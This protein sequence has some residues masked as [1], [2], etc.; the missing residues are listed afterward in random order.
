MDCSFNDFWCLTASQIYEI[1]ANK[2]INMSKLRQI[3]KLYCQRQGTRTISNITGVSRNTVKKY[4]SQFR[5]LKVP[6][7][8]VFLL[9]DPDLDTLFHVH[10]ITEGSE[11]LKELYAFFPYAENK[12]KRPGMTLLLLW[13]EY[14]EQQPGRYENTAFYSH[15]KKWKGQSHPSMHMV[16]KAGDKMFV[17]YAGKKLPLTDPSTGEIKQMEVFVAILGASQ[18]TYVEA[19][20]SQD[21]EDFINAC[22][23]ALHYFGGAPAAIVPDNLKA[24]VIKS[25]RYEPRL[26]NN[27]EAFADHYGMVVLPARTYKPKD[28]ALVEGAVKITYNRI[29]TKLQE[30]TF[31]LLKEMNEAIFDCLTN[32]N[33]SDFQGRDYSRIEQ[34]D[35]MEKA[36]LQALPAM[37]FAMRDVALVKVMKHGHI[38]LHCDKHYYSVPYKYIGENVKILYSKAKV[39]IYLK[40]ELIATHDRIK[41]PH[42]YTTEPLHMA[43]YHQYLTDWNPERFLSEAYLIH[44]DVGMFI[45]QV[46]K[47]KAHPEQAYKSCQGILSFAK[48][49]G[50]ERLIK[51][52]RRAHSYEQFHYKGIENI[53]QRNLDQYEIEEEP[54]SMPSHD[55][56]RGENNYK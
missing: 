45:E 20:G 50:H 9:N 18:L 23:N 5:D 48:R 55:N 51:A 34:F 40:L 1:M 12:L 30:R 49:V 3:I 21:M 4:I 26:N 53:L 6:R 13:K 22:Q 37:R 8:E 54:I 17:D 41:I 39:E 7:E 43:T 19:I 36:T 46:I 15:Y 16:H 38:C 44:E 47:R 42:Q 10:P 24:A 29:Y 52:C 25:S 11:R 33:Q 32:H 31:T 28:K 56:I 35:E 27:F 2:N 14:Y